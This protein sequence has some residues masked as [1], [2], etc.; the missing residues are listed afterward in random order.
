MVR[1][2]PVAGAALALSLGASQAFRGGD[3]RAE[4]VRII[5]VVLALHDRRNA[6][7]PH[8][9]VDARAR[10]VRAG[11]IGSLFKLHE[12]EVPDL[13]EAVAVLVRRT[14][15]AAEDVIAVVVE[16]FR[17]RPAGTGVAH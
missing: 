8:A 3:Q 7:Q 6:L 15:R 12:H 4:R 10:Q 9:G 16:D 2:H 1:N 5:V 13:D 11:A 17:A 14:R